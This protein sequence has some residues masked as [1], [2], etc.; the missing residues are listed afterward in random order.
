MPSSPSSPSPSPSTSSAS[1][2]SSFPSTSRFSSSSFSSPSSE[3]SPSSDTS[4]SAGSSSD[5]SAGFSSEEISSAVSVLDCNS[6][7]LSRISRATP[8][9]GS[10]SSPSTL[11][12]SDSFTSVSVLS[13]A[14]SSST[15]DCSSGTVS[16]EPVIVPGS[17][18]VPSGIAT[19]SVVPSPSGSVM[20]SSTVWSA[21]TAVPSSV[22]LETT[23]EPEDSSSV[24]L[25]DSVPSTASD[26]SPGGAASWDSTA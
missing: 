13:L 12:V 24:A 6:P 8:L 18:G 25:T 1:G 17:F 22:K 26:V 7:F 15:A 23:S 9:I 16:S 14:E 2:F 21:F 19:V 5:P 3:G 4:T 10:L 11:L 20:P